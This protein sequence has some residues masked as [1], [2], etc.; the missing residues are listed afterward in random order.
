LQTEKPLPDGTTLVL[1]QGEDGRLWVRTPA[2]FVDGRFLALPA[3]EAA[4]T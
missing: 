4:P 2:E 1:Y 3:P